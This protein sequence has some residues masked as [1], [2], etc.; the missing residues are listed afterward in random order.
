MGCRSAPRPQALAPR[1]LSVELR[2][3]TFGYAPEQPPLF[4]QFTLRVDPGKK[5]GLVGRSGGG[6]GRQQA[7][8]M[9]AAEA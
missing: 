7:H 4:R 6:V 2:D 8:S 5:V 9:T 3:V 1:D